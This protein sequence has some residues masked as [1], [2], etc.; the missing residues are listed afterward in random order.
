MKIEE[1]RAI[2]L[3]SDVGEKTEILS[4]L[5][6]VFESY[7]NSIDNFRELIIALLDYGIKEENSEIKEE[8]F[9]AILTAATYKNIDEINFDILAYNLDSLP[10]ECLHSALTTLGF[11]F[12]KDYIFYLTKYLDHENGGIRADAMNAI[13]EIEGYWKKKQE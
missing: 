1:L 2:L 7:N 4:H 9:D 13:N 5:C 10:E 12:K 11:T 8:I 3:G 6:D